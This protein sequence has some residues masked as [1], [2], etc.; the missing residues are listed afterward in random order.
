MK[1][2]KIVRLTG[3]A[4]ALALLGIT[5]PA[6]AQYNPT[7]A[8]GITASPKGRQF[9]D[10]YAKNHSPAPAPVEAAK[11]ACASCADKVITRTDYSARGAN[12][13]VVQ[14]VAHLCKTCNT[15]LK[16]TGV[17]KAQ[18]TVAIHTCDACSAGNAD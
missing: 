1:T 6:A 4:M 18:K 12:K 10:E 16:T 3:I 2:N 17:G 9:R 14:V 8:D 13:P 15:D 5:S 7:D 11:M